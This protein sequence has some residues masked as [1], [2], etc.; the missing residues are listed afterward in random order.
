[1]PII[2]RTTRLRLR[3]VFRRQKR[4]VE[5]IG[6]VADEHLD[7]HLFRRLIKLVEVRRFVLAWLSLFILLSIGVVL[8]VRALDAHY[9]TPHSAKGGSY[10]EGVLG[11]FTNAS[12]L[13]ASGAADSSVSRLVFA[14]LLKYDNNSQLVP[15]LAES[16]KVDKNA[17]TYTVKLKPGLTWH[18]G[19]PLTAH[20]VAFTFKLIQNPDTR[21][22]L[23]SSWRDIKITEVNDLTVSFTLA[24]K[25]TPFPHSLTTGIVPKHVLGSV[26][27]DQMRSSNFN[28]IKPV[29]AGP[30]RLDEVQVEGESKDREERV[31][32]TPFDGYHGGEPNIERFVI[33]TFKDE[34]SMIAEYEQK[35][36]DAMVGLATLPDQLSL[37]ISTLE[38]TPQLLGQVMV[39]FKTSEPPL[40]SQKIRSALVLAVDKRQVM[41]KVPYPLAQIDQPLLQSHIGYSKS[42]AQRTNNL[43]QAGIILD[44]LG[45]KKNPET[46]LRT[47]NG[48]TLKF[49]LVSRTN[50]EYSAVIQGLQEQWKELGVDVQVVLQGEQELQSTVAQHSYDALLYAVSIGPDPDVFAYWHSSQADVRSA[51]RLNFSEYESEIASQSLEAGRTRSDD[52]TRAVKY[53]AFVRQW[54]KD[55]PALALYQPRFLYVVRAPLHGF[56]VKSVVIASDRYST[57]DDWAVKVTGSY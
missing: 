9:K 39:F 47:K 40:N 50:T 37:D 46:G 41:S 31:G 35:Q 56:D 53:S 38:Y 17:T 13:Y 27:P 25:F 52:K 19:Q 14:G 6:A 34:D 29:G 30:F 12:P 4:Q 42:A 16:W 3:R 7:R 24:N 15:D 49:N 18:D 43:K 57:V 54:Q 10:T 5:D 36:I 2:N 8:Q 33:K 21:S 48:K 22:Y 23:E 20:D 26:S 51:T 55:V 45:W 11:T 32:L 1:M 28:T 44:K